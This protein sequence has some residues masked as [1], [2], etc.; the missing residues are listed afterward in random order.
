MGKFFGSKIFVINS[1]LFTLVIGGIAGWLL[2]YQPS[3][4]GSV[5]GI[6]NS[7]GGTTSGSTATEY[8]FQIKTACGYWLLALLITLI[9]LFLCITLRKLY[10]N[11]K[12]EAKIEK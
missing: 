1:T 7:F 10:I 4:S 2:G 6:S 5:S 8:V 3:V 11:H 12:T 9:V